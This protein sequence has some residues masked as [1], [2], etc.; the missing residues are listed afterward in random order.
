MSAPLEDKAMLENTCKILELINLFV[1]DDGLE[2]LL[3]AVHDGDVFVN[4]AG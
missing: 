2:E 4:D 3:E 1:D